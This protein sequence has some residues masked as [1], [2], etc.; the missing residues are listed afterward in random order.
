MSETDVSIDS[1]AGMDFPSFLLLD[2]LLGTFNRYA[3]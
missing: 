1:L 3:L 2:I